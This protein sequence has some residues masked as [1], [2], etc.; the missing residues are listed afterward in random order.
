METYFNITENLAYSSY[1]IS[2]L[3]QE[4]Q[5]MTKNIE[6]L[7]A[8]ITNISQ[9]KQVMRHIHKVLSDQDQKG[10]SGKY[11]YDSYFISNIKISMEAIINHCMKKEKDEISFEL[12]EYEI[13]HNTKTI[14][15]VCVTELG[16]AVYNVFQTISDFITEFINNR[17]KFI[18][19]IFIEEYFF[20][21]ILSK[22]FL[23]FIKAK[24]T[25]NMSNNK[26]VKTFHDNQENMAT[27]NQILINYGIS[28][29][30]IESLFNFFL[31]EMTENKL[32]NKSSLESVHSIK[33]QIIEAKN[34]YFSDLFK[35][36]IQNHFFK[37]FDSNQ[38]LLCKDTS[39]DIQ[40]PERAFV[41]FFYFV[42]NLAKTVKTRAN[43]PSYVQYFIIDNQFFNFL[44]I[45]SCI[46]NLD[47]LYDTEFNF[48]K[49]G[50]HGLEII[51]YG[52][53]FS[54]LSIKHL[55]G[56]DE[57]GK[58]MD[59]VEKYLDEFINDFG[60]QRKISTERLFKNKNVF[61]DQVSK[62]I[63]ENRIELLKGY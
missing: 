16:N 46:K 23:N 63:T 55:L 26:D 14:K 17:N 5:I 50:I 10:K 48:S 36:K 27:S 51:V 20:D 9:L 18:G 24:I 39:I 31:K 6:F 38:D 59:Y 1:I 11:V 4:I 21:Q 13:A 62:Y 47:K 30:S 61:F 40:E 42:K 12:K 53:Y 37:F 41:V 8:K 19:I 52:I 33:Q 57:E 45:I 15:I 25:K 58:Y 49:L 44:K 3:R 7:F 54:Y 22:E 43:D 2:W 28:I 60:K 34:V 29:L 56:F 32:V 35:L